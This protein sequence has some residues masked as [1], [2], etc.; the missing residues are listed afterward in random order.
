MHEDIEA[1]VTRAHRH[2]AEDDAAWAAGV[3]MNCPPVGARE[4]RLATIEAAM[5]RLEARVKAEADA[6]RRRPAEVEAERQGLGTPRRGKA[7]EPVKE[8]PD[9][10]TPT[11]STDPELQIMR[12]NG[13]GR[14][15]CGDAQAS[16]DAAH[17]IIV[18]CD[19]TAPSTTNNKRSPSR[20]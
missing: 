19:L 14:E 5:R 18:A 17:Q 7:P 2:D 1:L 11:N 10:K 20:R 13:K 12:T 15:Y 16:V 4:D 8:T 3:A 6:E 9:D